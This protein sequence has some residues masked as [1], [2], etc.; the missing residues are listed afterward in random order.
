[1]KSKSLNIFHVHC[2][3]LADFD[4]LGKNYFT[5]IIMGGIAARQANVS[6][7]YQ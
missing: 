1:M 7:G 6:I 5:Y 3:T 2:F 4:T